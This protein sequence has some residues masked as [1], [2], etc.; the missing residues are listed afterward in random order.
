MDVTDLAPQLDI[1]TYWNGKW[2]NTVVQGCTDFPK[3]EEPPENSRC[4]EG[5]A[6]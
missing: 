3:L 1:R 6:T 4:H 5:D 2:L